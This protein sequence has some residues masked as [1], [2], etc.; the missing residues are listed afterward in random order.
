M[1]QRTTQ[2]ANRAVSHK[3]SRPKGRDIF[4][5]AIKTGRLIGALSRDRRISIFR[6][7]LFFG[8]VLGLLIIL[9]FPDILDETFLSIV[10][11]L[12]GTILGVPLDI[13]FD[14]VAFALAVIALLHIFPAEIVGEHYQRLFHRV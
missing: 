11:P 2:T 7:V 4:F 12:L 6:K 10:L 8:L 5:H 14:W 1:T 13:G 3:V 9:L